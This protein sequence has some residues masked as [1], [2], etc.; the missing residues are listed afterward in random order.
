[1]AR[2]LT[3]L[4]KCCGMLFV[5]VYYNGTDLKRKYYLAQALDCPRWSAI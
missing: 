3:V 5:K 2:Y 1:M 4:G